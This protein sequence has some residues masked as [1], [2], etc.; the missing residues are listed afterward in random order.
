MNH[1]LGLIYAVCRYIGTKPRWTQNHD[2]NVKRMRNGSDSRKIREIQNKTPDLR[3]VREYW[4]LCKCVIRVWMGQLC[5][6]CLLWRINGLIC[7]WQSKWNHRDLYSSVSLNGIILKNEPFTL[8]T[9]VSIVSSSFRECVS[10]RFPCAKMAKVLNYR[11]QSDWLMWDASGIQ[12]RFMS[13]LHLKNI[14][15]KL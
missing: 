6:Y 14:H 7:T 8:C 1:A 5:V 4:I 13:S 10:G 2:S 12:E 11:F 9:I 3:S 15:I